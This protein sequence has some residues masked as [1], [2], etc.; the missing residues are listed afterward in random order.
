VLRAAVKSLA[1]FQIGIRKRPDWLY[2]RVNLFLIGLR[3]RTFFRRTYFSAYGFTPSTRIHI[4][5]FESGVVL[6]LGLQ[7]VNM[8][9]NVNWKNAGMLLLGLTLLAPA[10]FAQNRDR[11]RD[12]RDDRSERRNFGFDRGYQDGLRQGSEDRSRRAGYNFRNRDW[13]QGDRGYNKSMG[14]RGQYKQ[15]YRDGYE[16]GYQEAFNGRNGRNGD[17]GRDRRDTGN[18]YPNGG[19]GGYNPNLLVQSAQANGRTD[20]VYYGQRDRQNGNS[21][22]P[23]D[24][25][26][27]RD[28]DHGYD[29]NLG[30]KADFQRIY[31]E[32]F[33]R[34]YQQGYGSYGYRR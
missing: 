24:A 28:A 19:Y 21:A 30:S 2:V 20:G 17:W 5:K 25:K 27:Y 26:G 29:R 3:C 9:F 34:G 12:G 16:R 11:D 32:E 22:R 4:Q 1:E 18:G 15:G 14:A 31:R 8:N 7:G 13:Q 23:T 33:I 10:G 6:G